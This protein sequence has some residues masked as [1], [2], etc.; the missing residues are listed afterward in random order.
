[1]P[2]LRFISNAVAIIL[3]GGFTIIALGQYLFF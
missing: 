1:M 3:G 2:R